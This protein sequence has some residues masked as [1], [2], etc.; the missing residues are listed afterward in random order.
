M[1]VDATAGRGV[2]WR[3]GSHTIDL[4]R[5]PCVMGILNLT[6]DSFS[7]GNRFATLDL[8]VARAEEMVRE[9]ADIID[10]GGES[11]RPDAPPVTADEELRRVLPVIQR[12]RE[13]L[14]VPVSIDTYKARVARD[15]LAAGASIINDI[16]GLTFDPEMAETVAA[17]TAGVVL[18][19][20]RGRPTEMQQSTGYADLLGEVSGFLAHAM[21]RAVAAGIEPD[22][23]VVDPGIGFGKSVAG[24]LALISRLGELQRLGRPIL[25]GTSRKSF[26]GAVLDRPVD[27]RLFGTAA[28]MAL[29]LAFGASIFRVHDVA[30]MRDVVDMAAAI[31][32]SPEVDGP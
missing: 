8:A 12:L 21:D 25:V 32:R 9:G 27:Q 17:S 16:S 6:P 11:T 13:T 15:A 2:V 19:H 18:M 23:L 10:V 28:T 3:C 22:R 1:D 20:T 5:R 14:P 29:A 30:A 4:S 7:D 31:V 24:N 26:I